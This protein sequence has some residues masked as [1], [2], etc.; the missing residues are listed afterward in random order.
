M[1]SIPVLPVVTRRTPAPKSRLDQRR[2]LT[3]PNRSPLVAAQMIAPR[4]LRLAQDTN[5]PISSCENA[6]RLLRASPLP[7]RRLLT[8]A[9]GLKAITPCLRAASKGM[10]NISLARLTV[11]ALRPPASKRSRNFVMS[12]GL[13]EPKEAR[14]RG[15]RWST[16]AV[17]VW[18]TFARL[19]LR[20]SPF[21]W[22]ANFAASFQWNGA[23]R[24]RRKRS[25]LTRRGSFLMRLQLI[26][27]DAPF[28]RLSPKRHRF[29]E[30]SCDR[31]PLCYGIDAGH[32]RL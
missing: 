14:A 23:L 16:K 4:Q 32:R 15:P 19:P 17:H 31:F 8:A 29:S 3:S 7:V 26:R 21:C 24:S 28:L 13:T 22:P 27:R 5:C 10:F 12:A 1:T 9:T 30:L 11:L 20:R 18:H 25:R 6:S 2:L